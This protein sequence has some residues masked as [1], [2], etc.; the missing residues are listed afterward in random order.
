MAKELGLVY[1][2][3][4]GAHA[5]A[6]NGSQIYVYGEIELQI[7]FNKPHQPKPANHWFLVVDMLEY[8]MILGYPWLAEENPLVQDWATGTW[9]ARYKPRSIEMIGP[10]GLRKL[11]KSTR[12]YA[13]FPT[14]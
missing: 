9:R 4:P 5:E 3:H 12:A 10:E 6:F 1:Q 7:S 8:D 13:L 14:L 11:I 2:R